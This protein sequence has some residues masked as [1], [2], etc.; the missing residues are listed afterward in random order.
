[1]SMIGKKI[2]LHERHDRGEE[3]YEIMDKVLQNNWTYYLVKSPSG[4][5]FTIAPS[6]IARDYE[7]EG[8]I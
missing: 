6:A 4:M 2:V 5:Y 1:M 8:I 7:E 3:Y